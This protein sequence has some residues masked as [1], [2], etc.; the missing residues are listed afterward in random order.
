MAVIKPFKGVRYNLER[1]GDLSSVISQPYD[2]V[3][4][5]LQDKYYAQSDYTVVKIIKGK[6]FEGDDDQNN[7]YTR[8][9]DYLHAWLDEGVMNRD[10]VPALYVLHQTFTLPDGQQYT[11]KAF[12]T[13]LEISTFD[14]GIVLPHERTQSGPKLDRLNLG[15]TIQ[16]YFGSVFMLYP[17]EENRVNIILDQAVEDLSPTVV[18]ELFE[19]DVE[20]RFWV[21]TDPEVLARVQ[22]EMAPKKNLIIADGHHRYE[23]AINYRDEMRA[24]YPDAP[25]NAGFNYRMVTLVSMSDPGLVI[26]PTHRMVHSY[27]ARTSKQVIEDARAYFQV[28]SVPDRAALEAALA[29]ATPQMPRIGFYDGDYTVFTL[30][31]PEVMVRVAPDRDPT[32]RILDVSILH[33]VLIARVMGLSKESVERKDNLDYLREVEMGYERVDQGEAN[34]VFVMNPTRMAEV[35]A[36]TAADVKMPSKSTDFYPKIISGLVAMPVGPEERL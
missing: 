14:E 2:R 18:R 36:C 27:T 28:E 11:R 5:G 24:K 15:R 32:W 1:V 12:T 19:S 13:A 17:D 21:V 22:A 10:E 35:R 7:V 16:T 4:Y 8:A 34:F 31:D 26:L 30:N 6:E 33:E 29:D 9:R 25:A 3:R 23:T 20:Q